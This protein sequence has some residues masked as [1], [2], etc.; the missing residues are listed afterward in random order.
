MAICLCAGCRGK[1]PATDAE[2]DQ[3]RER[4]YNSR[5]RAYLEAVEIGKTASGITVVLFYADKEDRYSG[6]ERNGEIVV[7]LENGNEL[8][9]FRNGAE[10]RAYRIVKNGYQPED[11]EWTFYKRNGV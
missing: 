2:V 7:E 3:S 11:I 6:T 10:L 1:L 8:Y 9:L 5:A 4:F